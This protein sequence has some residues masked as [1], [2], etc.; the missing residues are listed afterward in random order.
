M[1][2]NRFPSMHSK[3][4]P[5]TMNAAKLLIYRNC[6]PMIPNRFPSMH[7][8]IRPETMNAAKLLIYRNLTAFSVVAGARNYRYRHSIEVP[9]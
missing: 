7:S 8:K 6:F 4:R 9:V 1:I 5:E 2:P 3:I